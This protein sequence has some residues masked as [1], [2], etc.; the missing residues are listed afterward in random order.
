MRMALISI[1]MGLVYVLFHLQGNTTDVAAFGRSVLSW[2]VDRWG[3][4]G[5]EYSHGWLIPLVSGWLV[6]LKRRELAAAP[7][8]VCGWGLAV[9]V[10]ALLLHW[11]GAKAQQTR[12]SLLGLILI[13]WGIPFYLYGWRVARQLIFPCSYLI[14][15]IP[16][17]F[18][19]SVTAPLRITAAATSSAILNGIGLPVTRV[20]AGI[21]SSFANG[22]SFDVA[23]ECSGLHSL[24]AMTALMAVYANMTQKTL[25]KQWI[26]FS[27]SIPVAL[28]GNIVRI[29]L[30]AL[31]A[32]GFG[33]EVAMDLWHDYSGYPIFLVGILLMLGLGNLLN[34]DYLSW[35][36]QW[37]KDLL[38]PTSS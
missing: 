10:F 18:L 19:D 6:W 36:N 21:Q 15:C 14:F 20:G 1:V 5:G 30:V 2:M 12:L 32:A 4:I 8:K 31:V 22:F 28:V 11:L 37:K 9:I 38:S 24:L 29:T 23:P 17:N 27:F 16:L 26:L 13:I 34:M 25:L 3:Q 35:W 7:K 33:Q